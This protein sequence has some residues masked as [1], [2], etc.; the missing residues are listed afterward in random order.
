MNMWGILRAVPHTHTQ[1]IQGKTTN[2][3]VCLCVCVFVAVTQKFTLTHKR[4]Q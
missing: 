2:V 1:R 3:A 4:Q